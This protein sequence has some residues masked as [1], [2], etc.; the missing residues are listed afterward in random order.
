MGVGD[1]EIVWEKC[2]SCAS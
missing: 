2:V 1:I